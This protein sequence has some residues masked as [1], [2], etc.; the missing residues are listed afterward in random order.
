MRPESRELLMLKKI[1]KFKSKIQELER[2]NKKLKKELMIKRQ[3]ERESG[4]I[5][6]R[7]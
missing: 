5:S 4:K 3:K 1:S 6:I 7:K 2:Q